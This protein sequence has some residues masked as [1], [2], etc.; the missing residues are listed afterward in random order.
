MDDPR[1]PGDVAIDDPDELLISAAW[2][3]VPNAAR[4]AIAR[5]A[6]VHLT[7]D[8]GRAQPSW[9]PLFTAAVRGDVKEIRS[10]I[11]EVIEILLD[12]GAD[13]DTVCHPY[14]T[15]DLSARQQAQEEDPEILAMFERHDLESVLPAAGK[16]RRRS[17]DD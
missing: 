16:R 17:I 4:A 3:G 14:R 15:V 12:A 10:G 7:W 9:T 2:H 6:N 13:P 11:L 8:R 5:G 1:E